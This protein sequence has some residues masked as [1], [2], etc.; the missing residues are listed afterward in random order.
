MHI[1]VFLGVE[2][3]VLIFAEFA[4]ALISF[5]LL[6]WSQKLVLAWFWPDNDIFQKLLNRESLLGNFNQGPSDDMRH[7]GKLLTV[8]IVLKFL[9]TLKKATQSLQIWLKSQHLKLKLVQK[10]TQNHKTI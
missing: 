1:L 2:E 3:M 10:M 5:L 4:L 8:I 9:F 7:L 6:F